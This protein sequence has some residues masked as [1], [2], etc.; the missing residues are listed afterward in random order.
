[1]NWSAIPDAIV[2]VLLICV[3]ASVE[4]H[5]RADISRWWLA[6]WLMILLHFGA[7][8]FMRTPGLWGALVLVVLSASLSWA[9]LLFMYAVTPCRANI[10]CH[11][12]LGVLMVTSTL[13]FTILV[14]GLG[15]QLAL[16]LAA[17]MLG[18][19]PLVVT[20]AWIRALNHPLR[21][22]L[23]ALY[24]ALSIF[25][26]IF[27]NRPG[28]DVALPWNAVMFT[29]FLGCSVYVF[30]TYRRP[31]AGSF[32]IIT[33]FILWA[34]VF[35]VSPLL[36][37]LR[38]QVII[39]NE[40]WNL[41]KFV[42]AMGMML[43]LLEEQIAHNKNLALHD[44]LT[45]LP[46][47]RLFEDRITRALDRSRRTGA[48][49]ALLV[50][51]LDGFKRVN[52]TLGH[53]VG[54]QVL[55]HTASI[56]AERVRHSDTVARTGGDEFSVIL[57]GITGRAEA[58]QVSESLQQLLKDESDLVGYKLCI[59]A[60]IGIAVFPEDASDAESLCIAADRRMYKAK[61]ISYKSR[62]HAV[63]VEQEAIPARESTASD[64]QQL[65]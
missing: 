8:L 17:I 20:L 43:L 50:I 19:T 11:W 61:R 5:Y 46:N 38:P 41:P 9:G 10:S 57:E 14:F 54:D 39:D 2:F 60:S 65:A 62:Q 59:G 52:D 24:G 55:Q 48:E 45:G 63:S 64:G 4:L 18:I 32:V 7:G 21:W 23:V 30:Y 58:E 37:A 15:G 56:F 35:V 44:V 51:D 1:M 6:G 27:Q 12:M 31:T 34:S 49:V 26:L 40:I 16:N 3:F 13:Y 53:H 22:L 47:R 42:V 33:G 28:S 25:L 36:Q 29:V